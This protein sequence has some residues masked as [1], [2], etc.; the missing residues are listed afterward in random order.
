MQIKKKNGHFRE[1]MIVWNAKCVMHQMNSSIECV[2]QRRFTT[3]IICLNLQFSRNYAL[4]WFCLA[5]EGQLHRKQ[6]NCVAVTVDRCIDWTKSI[7]Y[8]DKMK[9]QQIDNRH[10]DS[11]LKLIFLLLPFNHSHSNISPDPHCIWRLSLRPNRL[12]PTPTY[13]SRKLRVF[14]VW[15]LKSEDKWTHR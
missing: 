4:Q 1:I 2:E 6:S 15:F 7:F 11:N 10:H 12:R 9:W 5:I 8:H 13:D 3:K 14:L